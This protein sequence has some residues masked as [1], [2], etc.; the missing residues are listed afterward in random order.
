VFAPFLM[1]SGDINHGE[2]YR[3]FSAQ[4][5]PAGTKTRIFLVSEEMA[6]TEEPHETEMA[7]LW[8]IGWAGS[9]AD[10]YVWRASAMG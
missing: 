1:V 5:I 4:V 8:R 10:G 7:R 3:S 6:C 2:E 9:G